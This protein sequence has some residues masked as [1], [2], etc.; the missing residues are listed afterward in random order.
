MTNTLVIAE[1]LDGH[2]RKST[3]SAITFA[4]QAGGFF[5]VTL[6]KQALEDILIDFG[7][8]ARPE[9]ERSKL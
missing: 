5:E 7:T 1:M 4:Q 3:H 9:L 8:F 6:G 2:V